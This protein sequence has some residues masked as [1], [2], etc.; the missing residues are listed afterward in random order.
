MTIA[1][2]SKEAFES[3]RQTT[4]Q[5]IEI[6]ALSLF[7]RKGLSV[8][9]GEIAEAAGI[10]QGLMYSHYPSKDALIAE[11][12]RQATSMSSG[13]TA[14]WVGECETVAD[15][16]RNISVMMCGMFAQF[17]IGIDYFMFMTQVGM[18]DFQMPEESW[19]SEKNPNPAEI[20]AKLIVQGQQEGSVV[21]GDPLQLSSVYYAVIQGL[22]CYIITGMPMSPQPEMLN[23]ILLKENFL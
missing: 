9:V 17:P 22:C 20:L 4:R 21:S 7:A 14:A 11:L 8:K 3:M 10:S 15:K 13:Y 23:R 18:S 2:R 16:I 5:K 1:P 19:Y 6:A 12:V